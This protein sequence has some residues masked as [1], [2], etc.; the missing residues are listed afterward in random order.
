MCVEG[1]VHCLSA[2]VKALQM[3]SERTKQGGECA[4]LIAHADVER[5]FLMDFP[6]Q[7]LAR[8]FTGFQ[9]AAGKLPFAPGRAARPSASRQ[10]TV[11][12]VDDCGD[13]M[14]IIRYGIW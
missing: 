1:H 10:N 7:R 4:D 6:D 9:L 2:A 8:R 12:V 11:I 5:Q 13:H 3:D 14:Q